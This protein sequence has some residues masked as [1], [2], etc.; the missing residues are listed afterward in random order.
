MNEVIKCILERRSIRRYRPEQIP[1]EELN[2]ILRAGEY[3]PNAGGRQS[4]VIAVCQN[5][6]LNDALGKINKAAYRG[7]VA[8]NHVSADQPSIADD[9]S[10]MSGF[11]G[12][13]TV[14]TLF[15]PKDMR[16]AVADCCAAAENIMLAAHSLGVGSCMIGRAEETFAGERGRQMQAEWGIGADYEAKMHVLLGYPASAQSTAKPRRQGR[17][18]RIK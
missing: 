16:F 7:K 13:P 3:A 14:L 1:E 5:A 10:L 15:A 4:A 17:I 11:Y 8:E 2:M 9:A 12:A 6:A 18:V